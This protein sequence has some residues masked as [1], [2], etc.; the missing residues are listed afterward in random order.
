VSNGSVKK[1]FI[2][3]CGSE[4]GLEIQRSLAASCHFEMYGGSSVDDHGR[5]VFKNYIGDIPPVEDKNFI[6]RVIDIVKKHSID[7]IIPAHDSVVL[8]LAEHSEELPAQLITS[9]L[10]TCI[11]CRSKKKTYQLL[12]GQVPVP[13]TYS[14][15]DKHI[16]FPVFIKPDAGQ[17]SKGAKKISSQKELAIAYESDPTIIISEYLPGSEYT[18][19]CFTDKDRKLLFS[20]G[21]IRKRIN[22]G[23]SVDSVPKENRLFFELAQKINSKLHLRGAWFFQVKENAAG[24]FVLM[25]VAPRIA[26]TMGLYR[27]MGVNFTQLSLFDAMGLDVSIIENS[28]EVEIDRALSSKFITNLFYSSVYVDLDD[29]LIFDNSVNTQMIMFLYQ[30]RNEGKRI[31]LISRHSKSIL[32]TL[33]AYAISRSLFDEIIHLGKDDKKS[34]YISRLDAIFIDDSFAERKDVSENSNIPVF[35]TD[36]IDVLL[37]WRRK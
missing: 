11:A 7:F 5:L 10:E 28:F 26:G 9:P 20:G 8:K 31:C 19:D 12:T 36:A 25:E 4:I 22:N 37:D 6:P 18:I 13:K 14:I 30:A 3:P 29:T 15:D 21:R 1:V 27:A 23:I 24:D 34:H 17:G 2:F 35:A 33:E 32:K 16:S